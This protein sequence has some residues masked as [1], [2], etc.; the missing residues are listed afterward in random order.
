MGAMLLAQTKFANVSPQPFLYYPLYYIKRRCY[1]TQTTINAHKTHSTSKNTSSPLNLHNT[2]AGLYISHIAHNRNYSH[3]RHAQRLIPSLRGVEEK[4]I[5]S[6]LQTRRSTVQPLFPLLHTAVYYVT[7][8][9]N[10]SDTS[11][12]GQSHCTRQTSHHRR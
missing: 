9:S 7:L 6:P 12:H 10:G 1:N 8:Q 11:S 5:P 4:I 2:S 3:Q